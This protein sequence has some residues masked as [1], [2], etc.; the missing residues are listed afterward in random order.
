MVARIGI[1][2]AQNA[3]AAGS[4]V[5]AISECEA[6]V[7]RDPTKVSLP[8]RL[9]EIFRMI[10]L[11]RQ[12]FH[13]MRERVALLEDT[14][15]PHF[16]LQS[17]LVIA[18]FDASKE[19][20]SKLVEQV[21]EAQCQ[22]VEELFQKAIE[23]LNFFRKNPSQEILT[24]IVNQNKYLFYRIENLQK[25][26]TRCI[27]FT[28]NDAR[29][30]GRLKTLNFR[31]SHIVELQHPGEIGYLFRCLHRWNKNPEQFDSYFVTCLQQQFDLM[32]DQ[33]SETF[34]KK[35][36]EMIFQHAS[37]ES[38][39]DDVWCKAHR[40]DDMIFF[41]YA[42]RT[43][44]RN[45]FEKKV[46]ARFSQET[47][48][49]FY[50]ILFE[51]AFGPEGEDPQCWVKTEFPMLI[52]IV[53]DV[54][55]SFICQKI[56]TS[57]AL[58]FSPSSLSQE[59]SGR[60]SASEGETA[61]DPFEDFIFDEHHKMT[62]RNAIQSISEKS[63]SEQLVALLRRIHIIEAQAEMNSEPLDRDAI[64]RAIR[65]ML[66]EDVRRSLYGM[67]AYLAG[68]KHGGKGWGE[69]HCADDIEYLCFAIF[70]LQE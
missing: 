23:K 5:Q 8:D 12:E 11:R 68:N 25:L 51:D 49:E 59:S 16:F 48:D 42:I 55:E 24:K 36:N 62:Q 29:R 33:M 9:V 15:F 46:L 67:I 19:L 7:L 27:V 1:N 38:T 47:L 70:H 2:I 20:A 26:G 39:I 54:Y 56:R 35:L 31:L 4:L 14:A 66:S 69:Q 34:I 64:K 18:S 57:S 58:S 17:E 21:L 22:L 28:P 43:V 41:E 45:Q 37:H 6:K 30:I 40:Y 44:I 10:D 53:G 63:M 3:V 65:E 13:T 32:I 61:S 50:Q 60:A 52:H